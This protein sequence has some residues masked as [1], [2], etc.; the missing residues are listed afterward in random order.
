M[1]HEEH[2]AV[3]IESYD[4]ELDAE[5]EALARELPESVFLVRAKS[6]G[7]TQFTL[8]AVVQLVP[9][10]TAGLTAVVTVVTTWI[11]SKRH[12]SVKLG[13][14][15]LKGMAA[16]EIERILKAAAESGD[17]VVALDQAPDAQAA[18]PPPAADPGS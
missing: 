5:L 4:P 15:E 13:G 2:P 14:I 9:L 3:V 10:A 8:Q 16:G 6:F 17:V 12:M 1:S 11:R 7:A 18:P